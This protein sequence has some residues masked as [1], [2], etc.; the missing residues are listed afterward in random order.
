MFQ[1]VLANLPVVPVRVLD[2]YKVR[3]MI[4]SGSTSTIVSSALVKKMPKV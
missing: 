2:T 1:P 4:D 3:A